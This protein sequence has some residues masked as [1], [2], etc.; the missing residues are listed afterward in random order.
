MKSKPQEKNKRASNHP[1]QH[2]WHEMNRKQRR[3][4]M[5]KIQSEELSLEVVHP[6]AAGIDIGN[7]S[8]YVAVPP[9]R[10]SQ[11]VRRFGCTTAELKAMADWL[12]RC[13][14]R[15]IAM[16]STGVYWIAVYDILEEAGFEVYLVNARE[17]KNLP[18]RKT[19]VQESQWLMKGSV[20]HLLIS[21]PASLNA[22]RMA[23][24]TLRL[25]NTYL[26]AQFRRLRTKLGAPVA[27]KA[28]AAK[29]ARLVYRMLRYGMTFIDRGAEFYDAQHRKLQ[30][31]YLKRKAAN[32]GFQIIEATAA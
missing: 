32:L 30:I 5:R 2:H 18:G 29:L 3:E 14:V 23:A 4:T 21:H 8:H 20:F 1:T 15:T 17:T 22:L 16:Q 26:G 27:I 24:S 19:D 13:G 28:M 6:D 31:N 9:S 11:P 7:E 10:D 25:S 12:K